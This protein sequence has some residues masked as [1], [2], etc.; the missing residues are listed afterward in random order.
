[1]LHDTLVRWAFMSRSIRLRVLFLS[2]AGI[3]ALQMAGFDPVSSA[4]AQAPS[5]VAVKGVFDPDLADFKPSSIVQ[6]REAAKN[7]HGDCYPP[8][9]TFT[10][11]VRG[12]GD[13]AFDKRLGQARVAALAAVLPSLGLEP[14]QFR[15][16]AWT[17]GTTD[18]VQVSYEKFDGADSDS[19]RL[20]LTSTPTTGTKVK[21][22]DKIN[23][24]I[25]A[26]ERNEDG[27]KSFPTGVRRIK[28]F[29]DGG[30]V[31]ESKD[32]G[33]GP[34]PCEP[35]TIE[36]TYTVPS[37]PPPIVH[38]RAIAEDEIG[39]KP[40]EITV[41][42]PTGDTCTYWRGD[43]MS[44][45]TDSTRGSVAE[46]G[47]SLRKVAYHVRLR[48]GPRA[49]GGSLNLIGGKQV[50]V[51]EIPLINEG[52]TVEG[53]VEE[54]Q[55][56]PKGYRTSG[57]G[58]ANL[59]NPGTNFGSVGHLLITDKGER[60]EYRFTMEPD[61]DSHLFS[62][63]TRYSWTPNVVDGKAG[64]LAAPVGE[65][66]ADPESHRR[67]TGGGRLM[68][69]NYAY[70]SNGV[71]GTTWWKLQSEISPCVQVPPR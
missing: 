6:L 35:R 36:S 56:G 57:R 19:P 26:S 38:L 14:G 3:A 29:A 69:G 62:T 67:I 47:S 22:G 17:V 12:S 65:S 27:H 42:F 4:F 45:V 24:T 66:S 52:S 71:A 28:L 10:V 60:V 53:S 70:G 16:G 1:M 31:I 54:E 64:F 48:E 40:A 20:K 25:T 44:E 68:E 63:T 21:A 11:T 13:P 49:S 18:D 7:A 34:P 41:E 23:V 51:F 8:R 33:P 50:Y 58:T 30:Q 15:S 2:L 43:V 61:F 46:P 55:S 9:A 39:N 32:Y 59:L 37:D 5:P